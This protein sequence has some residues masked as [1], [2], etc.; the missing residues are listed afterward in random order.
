ML[1]NMQDREKILHATL[2]S[3][4]PDMGPKKYKNFFICLAFF[5]KFMH[6]KGTGLRKIQ[7]ISKKMIFCR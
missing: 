4:L 1:T 3:V 7:K 2:F 5:I 6:P